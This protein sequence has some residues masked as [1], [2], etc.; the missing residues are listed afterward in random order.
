MY[1]P[2]DMQEILNYLDLVYKYTG[3]ISRKFEKG[4]SSRTGDI[5]DNLISVR[6]W[7]NEQT[8]RHTRNLKLFG[9][10][11]ET[12]HECLPKIWES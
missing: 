11:V 10:S 12:S 2:T 3:N 4:S 1:R 8:N 6:K 9:T 7:G 5:I